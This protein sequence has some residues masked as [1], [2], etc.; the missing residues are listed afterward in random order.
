MTAVADETTEDLFDTVTELP[1]ARLKAQGEGLIGFADRRDKLVSH[2][3]LFVDREGLAEW[4]NRHYRQHIPIVALVEQRYPLV[5]FGGDVGTGKTAT[6]EALADTL[7]RSSEYNAYLYKLSMRVRG[8]GRV[9]QMS[10]LL[11]Q[12]FDAVMRTAGR[13]RYAA[14]ILDEAD[15]IAATRAQR[16]SHHEDKV[17]V[18]TLIQKI[19]ELRKY[20]G[21]VVVFLCTN[22]LDVLDPAILRRA[23]IIETFTRPKAIERQQLFKQDL[24]GLG[25]TNDEVWKL[26]EATDARDEQPAWTYSDL[27][28]RLY[29]EVLVRA[30]PERR[31]TLDDFLDVTKVL[32]PS[33][34]I[35]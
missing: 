34:E 12:A 28:T 6:A 29:P 30:Y 35:G 7:A 31:L 33:P 18:N 19:D 17:A 5:V 20:Q 14:L 23:A 8:E 25:F 9:G 1:D 16:H 26:V 11:S 24:S 22:R 4:T 27:R 10:S 2:L 15:S 32:S 13:A 21:R 3:R